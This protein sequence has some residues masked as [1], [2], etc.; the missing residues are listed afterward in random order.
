MRCGDKDRVLWARKRCCEVA[1]W[2]SREAHL[3][4]LASIL[5]VEGQAGARWSWFLRHRRAS[6]LKRMGRGARVEELH[7]RIRKGA[8]G[9]LALFSVS[10]RIFIA[11]LCHI[12]PYFRSNLII[13]I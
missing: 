8:W 1:F 13:F 12:M 3:R 7:E 2:S 11:L 6:R 4:L 10:N 5:A 9:Q